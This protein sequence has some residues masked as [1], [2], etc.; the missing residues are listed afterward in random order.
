MCGVRDVVCSLVCV[1]WGDLLRTS[2]TID[3]F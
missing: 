2:S 3:P 1:V